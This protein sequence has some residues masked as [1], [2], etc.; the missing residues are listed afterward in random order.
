MHDKLLLSVLILAANVYL[1]IES[2]VLL[3]RFLLCFFYLFECDDDG[4]S[5]LSLHFIR[6]ISCAFSRQSNT[7][8]PAGGM[9]V[10]QSRFPKNRQV[11]TLCFFMLQPSLVSSFN[12]SSLQRCCGF[13]L[14]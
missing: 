8:N 1:R 10:G 3:F 7:R 5:K 6:C 11:Q 13:V 9:N 2:D 14:V 4:P 12:C